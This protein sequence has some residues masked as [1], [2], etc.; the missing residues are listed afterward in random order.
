LLTVLASPTEPL[1]G[2]CEAIL[3]K[4]VMDAWERKQHGAR[5]D[6]VH[7]YLTSVEVNTAFADK[8]TII[9]RLAELAMLLETYCTWGPDGEYFN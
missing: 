9:A 7:N 8:P 3:Q 6:D 1:D 2:V 5:I 4:A